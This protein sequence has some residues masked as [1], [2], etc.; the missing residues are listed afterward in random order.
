MQVAVGIPKTMFPADAACAAP[1]LDD[2]YL[3]ERG[4]L[5]RSDIIGS[6]DAEI[7]NGT[8]TGYGYFIITINFMI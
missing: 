8:N 2:G 4:L 6:V 7:V 3:I 1:L 5:L